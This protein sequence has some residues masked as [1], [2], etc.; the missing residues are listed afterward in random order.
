MS[1]PGTTRL[2]ASRTVIQYP[3]RAGGGSTRVLAAGSGSRNVL[4]IH[5]LGA[6]ADR[7]RRNL[8]TFAKAGYRCAAADLP[9]HGFASKTGDFDFSVPACADL[10]L[11]LLDAL[12]MER[13]ALVGTSLGGFVGATVALLAPERISALVLVGT[14]GIAPMGETARQNLA[15]RFGTVDR[16]GIEGKLRTVI[17]DDARL[18]TESWIEEEWRINNSP[19][20]REAFAAISEYIRSGIDG[21]VVGERLAALA[22]RPPTAVV[23]GSED[24]AVPPAVGLVV[25]DLLHPELFAEIPG[26]GHCPYLEADTEFNRI[27]IEFL[28]RRA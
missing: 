1:A 18:V 2:G 9:G 4:F 12:Q 23:W 13:A 22:G 21:D 14:I 20:A 7:W 8:P 17:H 19:G 15:A 27:V 24:R 10:T 16:A 28:D 11:D 26:T 6:R 3:I 25:N 5:G